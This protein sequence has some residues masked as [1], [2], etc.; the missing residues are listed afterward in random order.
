MVAVRCSAVALTEPGGRG[1]YRPSLYPA[2][3]W[4]AGASLTAQTG[5]VYQAA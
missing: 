1:G 2:G 3:G 4:P 5:N